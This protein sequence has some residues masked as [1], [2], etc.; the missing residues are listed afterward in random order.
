MKHLTIANEWVNALMRAFTD[1]GLDT[2]SITQGM[3]GF[4]SG[5]LSAGSRLDLSAARTLWHRAV[6]ISSDPLLGLK[7]GASQDYRAVGVLAPVL[8]HSPNMRVALSNIA[9]YQTLISESGRFSLKSE[10]FKGARVLELEYEETS[11]IVAAHPQQILAVVTG[12]IGLIRELSHGKVQVL[13]LSVPSS[14]QAKM[15]EE[16]LD[17]EVRGSSSQL[18]SQQPNQH[19]NQQ[20]NKFLI[21]VQGEFLD[22]PLF[23]CDPYLYDLNKAYADDLLSAKEAGLALIAQVKRIIVGLDLGMASIERIEVELGL[24]KRTLQRGLFAQGTSFRRLKEEVLKEHAVRL[25][26]QADLG[27]NDIAIQLRYSEPSAFHRAFKVW[28]GMTPRQFR[29][30]RCV[31]I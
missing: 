31:T 21:R 9:R 25:L 22:A 4:E 7:V 18:S 3:P 11:N 15:I 30:Q 12:A 2:A 17:V 10:T 14:L 26:S 20:T 6:Q 23:G 27:L 5:R 24:N 19:P 1:L 29:K 16:A 8:W 13:G 28:F